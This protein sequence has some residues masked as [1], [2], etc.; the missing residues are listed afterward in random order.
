MLRYSLFILFVVSAFFGNH[1][2]A[3]ASEISGD[4]LNQDIQKLISQANKQQ[5]G[6]HEHW[7]KLLHY[8]ANQNR[9]FRAQKSDVIS[10]DF[11]LTANGSTDPSAELNA[12]IKAF[13]LPAVADVNQHALCRFPA[14]YAWLR[15]QLDWT[16]T[17]PP[18]IHCDQFEAWSLRG[19]VTGISLIYATGYLSNP[20]SLYGHLL[21]K[22]NTAD[23]A[24]TGKL[25]DPSLSY[26]AI[27]PKNENGLLYAYRGLFGGYDAGFSHDKF[28]LHNH[29]YGET[30]LR[31][32]WEYELNLSPDERDEIVAHSWELLHVRFQYYFLGDNCAYRVAD[33]LG[34]VID[35]PLLPNTPWSI[36]STVI[37]KL[38]LINRDERPIVSRVE[39]MP[40]RQHRLYEKY[41][42]LNYDQ[43]KI[44]RSIIEN[45]TTLNSQLG[46]Q[47][48]VPDKI[49]ELETLFDY[50]EFRA[51]DSMD[52]TRYRPQKQQLLV[53]RLRLPPLDISWPKLEPAP[54]HEGQPPFQLQT[55]LL[56][57]SRFGPGLELGMRPAYYDILALDTARVPYSSLTMFDLKLL[58]ADDHIRLRSLNLLAIEN[59]NIST[60]DLPGDGGYA[61]KL[62]SGFEQQDLS[63]YQ[64]TVFFAEGG[65]GKAMKIN[66]GA[67]VFAM[68]EGR[69][70]SR[71]ESSGTLAATARIG[72]IVDPIPG[73]RTEISL[74]NRSYLNGAKESDA[75]IRWS[76]RFGQSRD[77]DIRFD[78]EKHVAEEVKAAAT[79]YW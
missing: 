59:M 20:A 23:S 68:L 5:L 47:E 29:N 70:Q 10:G 18:K 42:S 53:E 58:Y 69:G 34:I 73:W 8:P 39:H 63:C 22:F 12:T 3:R 2:L 11:F 6:N 49:A 7:R 75:V 79:F 1:C 62:R 52:K 56:N 50:Y 51:A 32:L 28:F 31:D 14:R 76:N 57:N 4:I 24:T 36:P 48:S 33:L 54:P 41:A 71:A 64:C 78:Y 44:V 66:S 77:W 74:G 17:Q 43:Q 45:P 25:L 21:V 60:T 72:A 40:S 37:D 9:L 13:F 35:E 61:W 27:V 67:M 46:A 65:I 15:S 19:K 55:A 16:N 30:E 26:G 38:M